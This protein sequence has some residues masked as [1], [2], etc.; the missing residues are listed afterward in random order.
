[1][2]YLYLNKDNVIIDIVDEV[3]PV[4]KNRNGLTVLCNIDNAQG[5]IGSNNET[6]YPRIGS[7][8]ISTYY[9]IAIMASVD[10]VPNSVEPLKYKYI[11][12]EFVEN[13]DPYPDTN[14]TLTTGQ[15]QLNATVEYVAAMAN[16]EI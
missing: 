4:F 15:E 3:R 11:A 1:M 6:I 7:Q 8:F 14:V 12:G 13:T 10:T 5:Y 16:I 9:D 2:K